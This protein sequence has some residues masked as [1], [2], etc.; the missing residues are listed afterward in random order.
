M[1]E[2]LPAL[3]A[4]TCQHITTSSR[5]FACEESVLALA[6]SLRGLILDTLLDEAGL[7]DCAED[8]RV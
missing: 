6:L 2:V 1:R 5:L 4:A 7:E 3:F 8:R